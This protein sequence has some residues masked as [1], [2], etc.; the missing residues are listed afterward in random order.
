MDFV[1]HTYCPARLDDLKKMLVQNVYNFY[2]SCETLSSR[3][4][5]TGEKQKENGFDSFDVFSSISQNKAI[6]NYKTKKT[7]YQQRLTSIK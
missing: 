2:V 1:L 6:N 4:K 3:K 7:K 5:K